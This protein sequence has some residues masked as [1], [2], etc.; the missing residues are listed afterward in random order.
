MTPERWEAIQS[1]F[2]AAADLDTASR[3]ALLT[4]ACENDAELRRDVDALLAAEHSSRVAGETFISDA[5]AAAADELIAD[6]AAA[7]AGERVGPYRLMRELGH[8]GMGT[9][10]LAERADDEY[11][12]LVAIKFV[13]GGLAAADLERR[14]RTERQIL[15]NLTHPNIAWV[16]DAG[17]TP[18]G[19]PYLVMEYVDGEPID[20]WCDR[21]AVGLDARLALFRQVC[22]A[23]QHAHQALV[24]HSDLKPSNILVTADGT[25][26]LVDFGIA[27]LIAGREDVDATAT[28]A[29]L[30]PAYA[31]PEQVRGGRITVAT[32][33]YALG[34]VLYKL[35]ARRTPLDLVDAPLAEVER[36]ICE[37]EPPRPSTV[38]VG[39]PALPSVTWRRRLEGD[40]DTI[41]L[42]ALH[43]EPERRYASV[44]QLAEDIRRHVE[45]LPVLA[46][47]DSVRYRTGK[48][49][50]RHR[51]ALA[52]SAG[53]LLGVATLTGLYTVGLARERDRARLE[54]A[55]AREVSEFLTDLF[56]Q[57]DPGTSRGRDVT[58]RE[59]LDRGAKRVATDL[60]GQPAVQGALL[61]VMGHV[62]QN[63]GMYD[64][65]VRSAEQAIKIRRGL[66][67]DVHP[68]VGEST[69]D[70]AQ[71]L[72]NQG[73]YARSE[74]QY[75]ESL[76]I[77]RALHRGD[78]ADVEYS[79]GGLAFMLARTEKL[80]EAETTYR[81]ALAMVR[82]LGG[83]EDRIASLN[84]GLASTLQRKG[85]YAGA[86]PL[87]REAV[88]S[89]RKKSPIDSMVLAT[90]I[91]NLAGGLA[92]L[93]KG[94]EAEPL[95][96]EAF[97]IYLRF[98]GEAH[99]WVSTVR[100]GLSRVL[101]DRGAFEESKTFAL[102]A[103]AYDSA[104]LGPKHASIAT[105]LGRIGAILT[106]QGKFAEAEG[107]L[108]RA[109][110]IRRDA[111]GP[112]HPYT[113]ISMNELAGLY[114]ASGDLARAEPAYR[115]ALAL[116][117]RIHPSSHPYLAFTLTGLGA[118][119][120]DRNKLAQAES[121]LREA[122]AIREAALPPGHWA[123]G[124]TENI[125]GATLAKLGQHETGER[126]LVSG[127][128][129]LNRTL[130]PARP[131]SRQALERLIAMY[132]DTGRPADAARYRA[133]RAN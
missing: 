125:L 26:K 132:E 46:R 29:F 83:N 71:A 23:V 14:F 4:D 15:A 123:R 93:G 52:A 66:Y 130:G 31:A 98:F 112:E 108:Q 43:K 18:D 104:R 118:V 63:L 58:A 49:V 79:L 47:P 85:D 3:T 124:E 82:R 38:T 96:R 48:F 74:A 75:R 100:M 115:E 73:T 94:V 7:R 11:R 81:E 131:A 99:P 88:A 110:A 34:G 21:S 109:L 30:T 54:A 89:V 1:L 28:F 121:L 70:L 36:R 128:D 64:D 12:S 8:G 127:Y 60:A 129:A 72:Y 19:D 67:G 6:G 37:T 45:G 61:A 126:L 17:T 90:A 39:T 20:D 107:Y 27:K 133:R 87:F 114:R 22:A 80:D 56:Q 51:T 69:Y 24:V 10:Y 65:A 113:A 44:E 92:E 50:R 35:V 5:I 101:L 33:V 25:P 119:L 16:L 117:R 55:K 9:V 78:H 103:L 77:R 32:D 68:D 116:R 97:A 105:R 76:R 95:Y 120:L 86:V 59:L 41:T 84:D 102:Q 42:K 62:Y 40:L 57:S 122:L 106:E 53:A 2:L 111:L 91:N 13:R